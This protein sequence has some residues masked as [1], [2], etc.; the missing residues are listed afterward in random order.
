MSALRILASA[1]RSRDDMLAALTL[2]AVVVL[3]VVL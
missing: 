1:L 2:G 3:A